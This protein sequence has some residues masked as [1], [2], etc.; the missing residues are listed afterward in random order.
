MNPTKLI[1]KSINLVLKEDKITLPTRNLLTCSERNIVSYLRESMS[2]LLRSDK[3]F[4][5][6]QVDTEYNRVGLKEKPKTS[7]LNK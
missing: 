2:K 5:Y 3:F 7:N 1:I 6:Y 4:R